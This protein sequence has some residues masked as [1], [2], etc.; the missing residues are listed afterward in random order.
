MDFV[1]GDSATFD[2][3]ML[4]NVIVFNTIKINVSDS[5]AIIIIIELDL[6]GSSAS[7]ALTLDIR[8][9]LKGRRCKQEWLQ[10]K[11]H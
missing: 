11:H 9:D 2:M 8:G 4:C 6:V 1:F 5:I 10:V 3:E 7:N